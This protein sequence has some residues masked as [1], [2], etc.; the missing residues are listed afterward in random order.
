MNLPLQFDSTFFEKSR[1]S[2]LTIIFKEQEVS[3]NRFKQVLEFTDGAL[4]SHLKKLI[5]GDYIIGEKR[6]I[7]NAALTIYTFTKNGELKFSEYINFLDNFVNDLST[8]K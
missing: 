1:L 7:N 3:F 6:I 2:I 4:Y 5:D 8:G